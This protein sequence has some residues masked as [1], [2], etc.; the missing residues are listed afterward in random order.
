MVESMQLEFPYSMRK[1]EHKA[2]LT[3]AKLAVVLDVMYRTTTYR[4]NPA[5][6]F[7]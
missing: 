5:P 2:E 1:D 7:I 6:K 4:H 3:A